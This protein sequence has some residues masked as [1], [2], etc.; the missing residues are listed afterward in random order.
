M[1]T[2]SPTPAPHHEAH[3]QSRLAALIE[4]HHLHGH[5]NV[6]VGWKADPSL[7]AWLKQQ[8]R[9]HRAGLL[10]EHRR[11]QLDELGLDWN[12]KEE[13]DGIWDRHFAQLV[14]F[15]SRHGHA[16]VPLIWWPNPSLGRWLKKQRAHHRSGKLAPERA[17]RIESLGTE[18]NP[19]VAHW[20][21]RFAELA[22]FRSTH[23][24]A[25]VPVDWGPN[26]ALGSWLKK[27]R[28]QARAGRLR[29]NLRERLSTLDVKWAPKLVN[30]DLWE[31]RFAELVKFQVANGHCRV[32][33]GWPPSP[34]LA[35]WVKDQRTKA[36]RGSLGADMKARLEDLGLDWNPR[37][38]LATQ[39]EDRFAQLAE[40]RSQHGHCKVPVESK[41]HPALGRW[42]KTQ[43]R[44]RREGRL[45][46][47]RT[48]RLE[49]LGIEWSLRED[50][51]SQ[52]N[53]RLTELAEFHRQHGHF[54]PRKSL[55]GSLWKWIRVQ[56]EHHR[57]GGLA[58]DRIASLEA[59]G[60]PWAA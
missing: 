15:H 45:D 40:F 16:N 1:A 28:A 58:A 37:E 27:Q 43:R 38:K 23:G 35:S 19:Q 2:P 21:E 30:D 44:L 54:R 50:P 52:W 48:A 55:Q 13:R 5:A 47:V 12:P 46:P 22:E 49:S 32:P 42:L 59:L 60:F 20:E 6:P 41:T 34:N 18:W 25:N 17:A 10:P 8:R 9:L 3:W 57:K 26:P 39:W 31:L 33:G 36:R 11:L 56:R 24:H 53:K 51:E 7:G 14:D 29:R 4:F